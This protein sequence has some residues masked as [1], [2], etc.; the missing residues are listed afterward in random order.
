L[1][2]AGLVVAGVVG[3]A[4]GLGG[5]FYVSGERTELLVA[6]SHVTIGETV[7]EVTG[8]A[9]TDDRPILII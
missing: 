7:Y 5:G 4:H 9:G 1:S 8:R 2:E 3:R 6:G